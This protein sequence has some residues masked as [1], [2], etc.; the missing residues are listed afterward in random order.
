M[1]LSLWTVPV[2]DA[3]LGLPVPQTD[4]H[5]SRDVDGQSS[6]E[7]GVCSQA[8]LQ[9]D[10]LED[11]RWTVGKE[12]ETNNGG[13]VTAMIKTQIIKNVTSLG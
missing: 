3:G 2:V 1:T 11:Q 12:K 13:S 5:A 7:L 9:L 4:L 6:L 10:Q 8:R